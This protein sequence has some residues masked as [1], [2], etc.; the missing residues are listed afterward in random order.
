[1]KKILA[2][3]HGKFCEGICSSLKVIAGDEDSVDVLSVMESDA[4]A[5][6]QERLKAYLDAIPEDMPVFI[7]TDIPAGSTTTLACPFMMERKNVHLISGLN[8]GMLLTLVLTP[9]ED[10]EDIAAAIH[11]LLDEARETI[12]YINEKFA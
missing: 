12:T 3:T 5:T 2:M 10:S 9:I 6:V 7:L 4:P 1:M 11:T 8:L